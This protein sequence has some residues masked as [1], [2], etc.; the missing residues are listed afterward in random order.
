MAAWY[1]HLLR[2]VPILAEPR[3]AEP[4]GGG[5]RMALFSGGVDSFFTVL[6]HYDSI[7][8]LLF[9]HGFDVP[10][11]NLALRRRISSCLQRAADEL[12]SH[13]SKWKPTS[14]RTSPR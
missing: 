7:D 9:V 5:Q 12:A 8:A 14:A 6:K 10:L 11:E 3:P 13:S 1:P 4:V 2:P